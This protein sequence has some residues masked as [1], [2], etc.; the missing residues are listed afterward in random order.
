M[1]PGGRPEQ[2]SGKEVWLLDL[3]PAQ[4]SGQNHLPLGDQGATAWK[5][6]NLQTVYLPK[7]NLQHV[8]VSLHYS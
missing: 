6:A 1:K 4:H 5:Q 3:K 7:P 8:L 2:H